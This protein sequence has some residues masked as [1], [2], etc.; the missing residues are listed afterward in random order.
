ME[1]WMPFKPGADFGMLVRR[2][3]VD[4]QM[5]LPVGRGLA[6]DFVEKADE[7]L[8]PMALHA[9]ADDLAFQH[10]ECSE[11]RRRAVALIVMCHRPASTALHRQ[12]GLPQFFATY[13]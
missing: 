9:L 8:M 10:V 4:D 3:V 2:V 6:I 7:L 1:P 12:P 13:A 5:Q 11:Q